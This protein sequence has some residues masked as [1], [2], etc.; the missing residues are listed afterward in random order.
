MVVNNIP[1]GMLDGRY[2]NVAGD[3]MSGRFAYKVVTFS[4]GDSTPSVAD[5]NMFLTANTASIT[6]TDFDG[7]MSGQPIFIIFG[8][9]NTTIQAAGNLNFNAGEDYTGIANDVIVFITKDGTVWVGIGPFQN[10]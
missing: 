7:G 3:A 1:L 5:G 6:I 10:S 4:D 2:L 8:D 9:G